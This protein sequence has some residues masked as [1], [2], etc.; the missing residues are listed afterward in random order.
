M[1]FRVHVCFSVKKFFQSWV[2]GFLLLRAGTV[3]VLRIWTQLKNNFV[4]GIQ[5]PKSKATILKTPFSWSLTLG[6]P[7]LERHQ[8]LWLQCSHP[9][10]AA[11][12]SAWRGQA[13]E[14]LPCIQTGM[15]S[16][17]YRFLCQGDLN[18]QSFV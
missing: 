1:S 6:A 9:A 16:T 17:N 4:G 14:S 10:Y 12:P 13:A 11:K 3:E 15:G 2:I 8:S 7:K 5:A 18:P